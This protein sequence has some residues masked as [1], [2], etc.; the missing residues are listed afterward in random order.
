MDREQENREICITEKRDAVERGG[1]EAGNGP[2][3][4]QSWGRDTTK[5]KSLLQ[6]GRGSSWTNFM[7]QLNLEPG[8]IFSPF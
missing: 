1:Q 4:S 2:R 5:G 6:K 7:S 8:L 3:R